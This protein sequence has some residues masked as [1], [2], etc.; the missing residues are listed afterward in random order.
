[1]NYFDNLALKGD[2]DSIERINHPEILTSRSPELTNIGSFE[3][4]WKLE[5][6]E[7]WLYKPVSYTH[8][9]VYKRQ[10]RNGSKKR[11]NCSTLRK[12]AAGKYSERI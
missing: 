10:L 5:N 3:K 11:L 2:P 8:L 4:C 7:W 1:M 6:Q 12:Q 9:D